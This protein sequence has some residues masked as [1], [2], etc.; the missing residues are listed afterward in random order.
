MSVRDF[1]FEIVMLIMTMC[2]PMD[3]YYLALVWGLTPE[4]AAREVVRVHD[5]FMVYNGNPSD[6]AKDVTD[7]VVDSSVTSIGDGAFAECHSLATLKLPTSVT[8]IRKKSKSE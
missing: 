8:S 7:V 3:A 2:S 6:V 5:S 1:P 4:E